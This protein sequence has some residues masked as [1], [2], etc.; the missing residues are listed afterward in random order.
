VHLNLGMERGVRDRFLANV[1]SAFRR[2]QKAI[3]YRTRRFEIEVLENPEKLVISSDLYGGNWL[4]LEMM[5]GNL[6]RLEVFSGSGRNRGKVILR[7]EVRRLVDSPSEIVEVFEETVSAAGR[8][9][10]DCA[11]IV[12][13]W[14]SL[15]LRSME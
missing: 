7:E 9:T 4:L 5:E 1:I 3:R 11:Q 15:T 2:R 8:D 10:V 14:K 12:A 6:A 13:S